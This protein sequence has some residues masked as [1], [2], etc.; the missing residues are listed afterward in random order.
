MLLKGNAIT[1]RHLQ[2]AGA[3]LLQ[4][5]TRRGAVFR[6]SYRRFAGKEVVRFNSQLIFH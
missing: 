3:Y 1:C 2:R 6:N 5:L 4:R